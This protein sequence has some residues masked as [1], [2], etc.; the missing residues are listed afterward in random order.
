MI[1]KISSEYLTIDTNKIP[2][3][4][5]I[6]EVWLFGFIKLYYKEEATMNCNRVKEFQNEQGEQTT[7]IGFAQNIKKKKANENKSKKNPTKRADANSA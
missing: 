3:V 6:T 7:K 2:F 4:I 5:K 1:K